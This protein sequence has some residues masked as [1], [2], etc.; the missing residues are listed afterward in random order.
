[1]KTLCLLLLACGAFAADLVEPEDCTGFP[2][3]IFNE[4]FDYF[5]HDVWEHEVT[6]SGGGNWEFQVYL[7][8][9]SISYTRD[10]TLFIKPDL[11]S[12]WQTEGFLTSGDL[13]LW[14]M[15]GRGDVCTGNSYYG[16]ERTGNAVNII[17]PV[18]SARL[19]TLSDFAFRYGRIE[20]RAKMPR[21]DWL[22]PAIWL[23]PRYWPYGL[24]PAS[25]EIDIVESRGNENYGNLGNQYGGSTVHWGPNW[26]RNMYELTHTDY[27]ASDGSF[28][29]SFHTWRLDWTKDNM[30]FY[31]DDQLQLTVDPGT[32][33]WD[34]GGFGNELDNPWK[35]GSKMAPFDQKFYVVLNVA[36]GGVNGFFPDGITD[37]P[38][39]NG[40]PQAAL[41]FWNG[42]DSWLPTWEQGEGRISENA[43]LQVDY[44]KVWKM[45]SVDQ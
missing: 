1:M 18:M 15:N 24:W 37:K 33:F 13:N 28:A 4:E 43:A 40:S 9:R 22:W 11:T 26:Q 17:N 23:L 38:W 35:A 16:C 29:N 32:N 8:N 36:V 12:N 6:M 42:R 20:V 14:G 3:L 21:G 2:C 31:L 44:V 30:L 27:A 10:S 39:S 34:F 7:N 25:G 19:R 45:E 5:D 41:D